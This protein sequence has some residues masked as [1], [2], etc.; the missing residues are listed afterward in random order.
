MSFIANMKKAAEIKDLSVLSVEDRDANRLPIVYADNDF[1]LSRQGAWAIHTL[2]TKPWG[3]LK[4]TDKVGYFS[5]GSSFFNRS[6]PAE[7]GNAG[8]L[9]VTNHVYSPEAWAEDLLEKH[10]ERATP[11]FPLYLDGMR[12]A[13][14]STEFF[15]RD[16][17]LAT[18]LGDRNNYRG[19]A[20]TVRAVT[21]FL[22][23]GF[24]LDDGQ[25]LPAE[26]DHW[27]EQADQLAQTFAGSWFRT[28][29]LS[30]QRIEWLVRHL[31]TPALPTPDVAP[32]DRQHWG[33]GEWQTTLASYTRVVDI[34]N[35]GKIKVR[36]VEFEA[37]TGEGVSYTTYLPLSHT[38]AQMSYSQK[39][40]QHAASL[41]FPVDISVHFEVIDA[42]RAKRDVEKPINASDAQVEDDAEA[43]YRTDDTTLS[44]NEQLRRLKMEL[45]SGR[46]PLMYWQA[47]FA[48]SD[49]T[50]AG[51]L[52]KVTNL[53]RHYK[54]IEFE[55]VVPQ[56][57]QRELFY[58]SFPGADILVNDWMQKTKTDFFVAGQPWVSTEV[59]DSS[60][61]YQGFTVVP[62]AQGSLQRGVPVFFDLQNV[63][64]DKGQAPTQIVFGDPGS[65]K[66]VSQGLKCALEDAYKG[67]TQFVWD[68]KGDFLP[69]KAYAAQMRL[70]PDKVRLIDL[71]DPKA[72]ISLDPFAI[73]EI[74][75]EK[76]ID[77]RQAIAT[78]TLQQ[79]AGTY[80][81][82]ANHGL[83]AR[84]IIQKAVEVE[85]ADSEKQGRDASSR[86]ALSHIVRWAARDLAG[87]DQQGDAADRW[88]EMSQALRDHFR[89]VTTD[90]L[91]RLIFADPAKGGALR[92]AAGTLTIFVALNMKP[93]EPGEKPTTTSTIADVI[94]GLMT[95]YI[96]S[97]LYRL[98]DHEPKSIIF[99]EWHVIK[100]TPRADALV[101][102][103]RRMGRSK[104]AMVR[105]LSQNADD[106]GE[107]SLSAVWAGYCK[108]ET[109]AKAA[110]RVIGIEAT[111]ANVKTFLNLQAGEFMF[112]DVRGRIARVFVDIFDPWLLKVFNTQAEQKHQ[113][114]E[115][116]KASQPL[117]TTALTGAAA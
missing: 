55:L 49:T 93:T 5:S 94:A 33:I 97:L 88:V 11:G 28:E 115:E 65:G 9:L 62:D 7:R 114:L 4:D 20:G 26:I 108:E 106:F 27:R 18:R 6:F 75:P 105:Q 23:N 63:V 35:S 24:G 91:G 85:L 66:T 36:A 96:R 39:W 21:D 79:L 113:L 64:D 102:W 74:D 77:E 72:S 87:L 16:I 110:C 71:Y 19:L 109:S 46:I 32:A 14:D 59:G 89:Q 13:I 58:Q 117:A 80:V 99:D 86:G 15:T 34:G 100:R 76:E 17:Y 51:L 45:A 30:R 3:Y 107:G 69:L 29:P 101:S 90:T 82:D 1:L 42:E 81:N 22:T 53:I 61:M 12:E 57:D 84:R 37:P 103:L 83:Q 67:V 116:L 98:P 60:G 41:P 95:D 31:D 52:S 10:S 44:Q 56:H 2:P 73:A 47:V 68:P 104:R 92:V 38:P 8:H 43:G 40:M 54:D 70:D 50:K 111:E 78:D 48:V 112:R 25:P